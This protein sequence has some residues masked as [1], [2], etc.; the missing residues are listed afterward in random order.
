MPPVIKN[1]LIINVLMFFASIVLAKFNI[2]LSEHLALYHWQSEKFRVWQF[3]THLFMHGG[4][5]SNL[6]AGFMH[7]L[8]NMFALWMFGTILENTFGAKKF[9][10]FYML[11][12]IGASLLYLFTV[13][14]QHYQLSHAIQLFNSNPTYDG[15]LQLLKKHPINAGSEA[16][17][18]LENIRTE[19]MG[20]AETS[21][22]TSTVSQI[23]KTYAHYQINQGCVGASGAVFGILFA[24]GY[25]FPNTLLYIYFLVPIKAKYV[26][27]MYGLL[28]LYLG[29]QNNTGDQIA[30]FAHVGG[31]VVA[32]VLLKIWNKTDRKNFF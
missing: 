14:Y 9:L 24:F 16:A 29:L 6:D 23:Y 21:N 11:C 26:V 28:E 7:L 30:H 13:S 5:P 20:S 32:W 8:S 22:L 19:W 12:G 10:T 18:V 15:F 27:A 3:I 2:N 4:D 17:I 1:L 31:M 25:L